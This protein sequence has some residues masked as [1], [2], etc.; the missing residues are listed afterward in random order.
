MQKT[1]PL[2]KGT[3][4]PAGKGVQRPEAA[5]PKAQMSSSADPGM[6]GKVTRVS[7]RAPADTNAL[8]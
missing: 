1:Q 5:A 4:L 6:I 7:H 3:R 8:D 2:R